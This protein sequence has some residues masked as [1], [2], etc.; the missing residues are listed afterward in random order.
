MFNQVII[1]M[2]RNMKT[3][4]TF[5]IIL[6]LSLCSGCIVFIPVPQPSEMGGRIDDL[7]EESEVGSTTI[8]EIIS[9]LGT[10][11]VSSKKIL[12]YKSREYSGGYKTH[13]GVI[14][15]GGAGGVVTQPQKNYIDLTFGFDNQGILTK[16]KTYLHDSG[17]LDD[18]T[19]CK[20]ECNKFFP[21]CQKAW[22]L[23]NKSK[24]QCETDK[25][26][27]LQECLGNELEKSIFHS[28]TDCDPSLESCA[29]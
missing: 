22:A 21:D 15:P 20:L 6:T 26:S 5:L 3:I 9:K 4:Q 7:L 29:W 13:I 8:G 24:A 19:I 2:R 11:D 28:H 27:C 1:D 23:T 14:T 16:Y 10:A 17:E 25:N 18:W 12:Y